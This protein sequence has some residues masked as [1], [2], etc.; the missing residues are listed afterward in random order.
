VRRERGFTALEVAISVAILASF[1]GALF[2]VIGGAQ[3]LENR[4]VIEADLA[5]RG[6][7]ALE[8]IA[9]ELRA[10]SLATVSAAAPPLGA[11]ALTYQCATG[12]SGGAAVLGPQAKIEWRLAPGEVDDGVDNNGNG[13][14]DEG[15]VIVTEGYGTAQA[16]ASVLCDGV[17]RLAAGEVANGVDDNGD[18]LI[19]EHGLSFQL[20]GRVLTIQLTLERLDV[21]GSLVQRSFTTSVLIQ[22]P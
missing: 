14:V 5:I 4:A 16:V 9:R 19:D 17:A 1:L 18:G 3:D 2:G 21:K 12:W 13:L 11:S 10:A 15:Q 6:R 20:T 8:R 7:I 22:N